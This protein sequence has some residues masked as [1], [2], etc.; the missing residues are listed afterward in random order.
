MQQVTALGV[1]GLA[2]IA[3]AFVVALYMIFQRDRIRQRG[4]GSF[5]VISVMSLLIIGTALFVGP[6]FM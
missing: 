2:L 1:G 3:V 5:F 6:L 4:R